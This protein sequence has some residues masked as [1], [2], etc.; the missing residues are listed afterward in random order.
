MQVRLLGPVEVV[1]RDGPRPV[2]GLRRKAILATLAL[3]E[4][5]PI[6]TSRLLDAV[7]GD[8]VPV[9][10]TLQSHLSY[11][12]GVLGDKTAILACPP[13]Y[14][15]HLGGEGT[16]VR[17]AERLWGEGAQSADPARRVQRLTEALA[18]WRGRALADVTGLAWLWM[19]C[20]S[21]SGGRCWRPG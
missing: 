6:S 15:L 1:A 7:W 14:V 2:P 16:D 21:R 9:V 12:R 5:E 8:A 20:M 10:N 18:L 3:H 19:H 17:V 4:G 13:G 11:L